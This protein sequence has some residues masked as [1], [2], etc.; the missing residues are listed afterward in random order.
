[1][2]NFWELARSKAPLDVL[3]PFRKG[4]TYPMTPAPTPVPTLVPTTPFPTFSGPEIPSSTVAI[5]SSTSTTTITPRPT[6]PPGNFSIHVSLPGN[7]TANAGFDGIVLTIPVAASA[8]TVLAVVFLAFVL[9]V[10]ILSKRRR[11]Q[12][13]VRLCISLF[14][15]T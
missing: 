9:A 2:P 5:P 8:G 3:F 14:L 7:D 12:A 11:V 6:L 10:A 1:V 15:L 4:K 13:S